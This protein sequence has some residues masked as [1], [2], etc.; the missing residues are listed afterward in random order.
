M[1]E[2]H[3]NL[4]SI[5]LERRSEI[6]FLHLSLFPSRGP[7]IPAVM[8]RGERL[9]RAAPATPTKTHLPNE[10]STPLE[11]LTLAHKRPCR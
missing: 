9:A 3:P 10:Y 6:L 5:P 8:V 11:F 2:Q 4:L 7:I 1:R